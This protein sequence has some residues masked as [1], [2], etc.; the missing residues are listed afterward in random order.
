MLFTN[1]DFADSNALAGAIVQTTGSNVGFTREPEEEAI[2][3]SAFISIENSAWWNWTAP[4]TGNV[5]IDTNG[6]NFDT[7][8]FV[9]TGS[10]IDALNLVAE[11]DDGFGFFGPSLVN[12]DVQAG[13]TYQIAVDGFAGDEG[14]I[15]LNINLGNS[16]TNSIFGDSSDNNLPGTNANDRITGRGGNDQIDGKRGDDNLFGNG[17]N[18]IINGGRGRDVING[19]A[20]ADSLDGGR[21]RDFLFGGSGYDILDGG[22]GKDILNGGN[23]SDELSG[24]KGADTLIG[25]KGLDVLIGGDGND[26]FALTLGEGVDIIKDFVDGEDS[27]SLS[28]GSLSFSDLTIADSAAGAIIRVAGNGRLAILEGVDS[29]LIDASDFTTV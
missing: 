29:S 22:K 4:F 3:N 11:N 12:F 21:G 28:N 13:T 17:G 19:G 15:S 10:A 14:N 20:G 26:V 1:D 8:L 9:L 7:Q 23:G 24:G 25:G 5:T 2:E 18:D 6:S 27:L 16:T